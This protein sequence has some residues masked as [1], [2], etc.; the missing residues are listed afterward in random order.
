[1]IFVLGA[2]KSSYYLLSYLEAYEHNQGRQ[3]NVLDLKISDELRE[4]FSRIHFIEGDLYSDKSINTFKEAKVVV[5]FLPAVMHIKVA[6]LCLEHHCHLVTASYVSEKFQEFHQKAQRRGLLFMM[7]MGLDPGID[8]M[9]AMQMISGIKQ[10]GYE[11]D[12]FKSY[13][14]AL[15][16]KEADNNPWHYKFTWNPMNVVLAGQTVAGYINGGKKKYLSSYNVF[17]ESNTIH[18]SQ[19]TFDGYYNRDSIAYRS[20]YQLEEVQTFIRGTLRGEGFCE[21]WQVLVDLGFT[22][23][24]TKIDV[25]GLSIREV[26]MSFVL[27][28]NQTNEL[29]SSLKNQVGEFSSYTQTCL[30][31][32]DFNTDK[33]LPINMVSPAEYLLYILSNKWKLNMNDRDRIVLFHEIEATKD[34]V[35]KTFNA[36]LD[37]EGE[38]NS[39]TAIAKTVSLPAAI[40]AKLIVEDKVSLTGVQIPIKKEIYAPILEELKEYGVEMKEF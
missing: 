17:R 3:L 14:G 38:S 9:S 11:I 28:R 12:S 33:V 24:K 10:A 7:E 20:K 26:V 21:A 18:T 22:H 25:S 23:H 40:G 32:L 6:E 16:S 8:H 2:G 5:S 37:L 15:I 19:G 39:K 4:T 31:Y 34:G 13:C 29:W 36:V 27:Q 1:M 30:E 35:S